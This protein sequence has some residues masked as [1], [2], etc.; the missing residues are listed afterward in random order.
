MSAPKDFW[1]ELKERISSPFFG[2]FLISWMLWNYKIVVVFIFYKYEHLKPQYSSFLDVIAKETN[3][4]LA[5]WL[6]IL[7]ALAYTFGYPYFTNFIKLYLARLTVKNDERIMAS[8]DVA[9]VSVDK[10]VATK[11]LLKTKEKELADLLNNEGEFKKNNERLS[12]ENSELK[13]TII[14]NENLSKINLDNSIN[15]ANQLHDLRISELKQQGEERI[16][17]I[18]QSEKELRESIV[19]INRVSQA[20]EKMLLEK[21]TFLENK[22]KDARLKLDEMERYIVK[23]SD[24]LEAIKKTG[25]D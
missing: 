2:S 3:S 21:V 6:P 24:E 5:L 18:L 11:A 4:C 14:A 9:R 12:I 23:I 25:K 22:D 20:N 17:R 13:A 7:C 8:T 1:N 19:E 15:Q 16:Q 10:F